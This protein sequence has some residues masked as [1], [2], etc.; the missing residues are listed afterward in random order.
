M[1]SI[2]NYNM[3]LR[4]QFAFLANFFHEEAQSIKPTKGF[5]VR[6]ARPGVKP[7]N[8]EL[9]TTVGDKVNMFAMFTMY[10]T[11]FTIRTATA[12]QP[13]LVFALQFGMAPFSLDLEFVLSFLS[14]TISDPGFP[15]ALAFLVL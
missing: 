9:R 7:A 8:K 13:Y 15:W 6:P 10:T 1:S 12:K 11:L 14:F 3:F 2:F 5:K 4:H